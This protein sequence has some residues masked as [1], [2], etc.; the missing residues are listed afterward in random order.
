LAPSARSGS[1][2]IAAER[3]QKAERS[4]QLFA[5]S[6]LGYVR[7]LWWTL[8]GLLEV[9]L[10]IVAFPLLILLVGLP[11]VLLI[12]LMIEIVQMVS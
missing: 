3:T 8:Q 4:R 10:V 1:I 2:T 5:S 6:P 7:S 9:V 12:R 11:V